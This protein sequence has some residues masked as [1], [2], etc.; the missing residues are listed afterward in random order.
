VDVPFDHEEGLHQSPAFHRHA[1]ATTAELFYDLFFVANLTT[2][3][4][5][6][7]I[8]DHNCGSHRRL[9][10]IAIAADAVF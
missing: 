3:T 7:E 6:L 10:T 5:N 2:F 8:N 1:E 9:P 4:A